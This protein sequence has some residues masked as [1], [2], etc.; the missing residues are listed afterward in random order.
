[1]PVRSLTV[2]LLRHRGSPI[3]DLILRA[4]GAVA[5]VG[6]VWSLLDPTVAALTP[7]VLYTMWA[8]GPHSP[9][10]QGAYEPV[11]L[12]YGQLFS[13]LLIAV[14][15]T[16]ATVFVEWANYHIY[17]RIRDTR[18]VG[19]LAGGRW[20]RRVTGMF[21]RRPFLTIVMCALGVVPYG[22]ARCLSVL[23]RYPIA[24]HLA[25]TALGRFPRLWAIAALGV[26]LALPRSLLIAVVLVSFAL[27]AALWLVGRRASLISQ[28]A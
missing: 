8:N 16:A 9:V 1:M 27:A 7:F 19:K 6:I 20:A 24:R 2:Q 28:S 21:A 4:F 14:L 26:S 3:D 25:A 12:L 17:A 18:T 15:G 11:L 23:S 5:L 13:P 22:V 10:L